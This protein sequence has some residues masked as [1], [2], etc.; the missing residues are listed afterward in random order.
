MKK[1]F[2]IVGAF[3]A[4][5]LSVSILLFS[6]GFYKNT[7]AQ[8]AFQTQSFLS[9]IS[10]VPT[11][12]STFTPTHTFTPTSTNTLT[13]TFTSTSTSTNTPTITF[14]PTETL[15]PT[16]TNTP[17]ITPTPTRT[18]TLTPTLHGGDV[19]KCIPNH[20]REV[21]IV[22]KIIDGD[23]IEVNL[24]GEIVKVRYI[25][26][27]APEPNRYFGIEAKYQNSYLVPV[28]TK[29]IMIKD[30]SNT[31]SFGRLLRYVVS[32]GYF[33][34]DILVR[35]G[36]ALS[37]EYK[38]DTS[39]TITFDDAEDYAKAN[40]LGMF[41]PTPT[42]TPIVRYN[43]PIV[44]PT[45]PP[46][47]YPTNT[48]ISGGGGGA[49]H[50]SYPDVCIPYPPPDLDCSDVYPICNFRV[51]GDDPHRFDGNDNDGWGCESCRP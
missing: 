28:N 23:T 35:Q 36:Y 30:K 51:I 3:S 9:T 48:P 21:A 27:D 33:V 38:P 42:P 7:K 25:G 31:D 34:N 40:K 10:A 2:I 50:P 4:A 22:T 11:F 29:I 44:L 26:M 19:S 41:K 49:C 46:I 6:V 15:T 24:N 39:C 37:V 12:T 18:Y 45:N 16:I 20:P 14:T 47:V 1:A 13:P 8:I 43:P 5:I 32:G 17:T